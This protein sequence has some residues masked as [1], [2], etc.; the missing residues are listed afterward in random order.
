MM[1]NINQIKV[2]CAKNVNN[3]EIKKIKFVEFTVDMST[4]N[5]K[6]RVRAM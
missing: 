2:T 3:H 6:R 4:Q 5:F 1:M